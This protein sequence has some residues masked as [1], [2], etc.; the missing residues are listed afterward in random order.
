[1]S[2]REQRKAL[3]HQV[4]ARALELVPTLILF[5]REQGDATHKSVQ[6]YE[7]LGNPGVLNALLETWLDR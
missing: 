7:F 6:N 4:T 1:V 5:Y 3:Y 2:D